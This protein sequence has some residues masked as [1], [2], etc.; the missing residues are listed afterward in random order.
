MTVG[1]ISFWGEQGGFDREMYTY[2]EFNLLQDNPNL[3]H[4]KE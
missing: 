2:Y 4:L 1:G 3:N